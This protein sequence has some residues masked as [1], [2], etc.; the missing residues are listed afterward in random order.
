MFHCEKIE[1]IDF[2][3]LKNQKNQEQSQ[4]IKICPKKNE[5]IQ[6]ITGQTCKSGS[7]NV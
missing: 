5:K 6:K 1:K 7:L 2:L 4:N 3:A